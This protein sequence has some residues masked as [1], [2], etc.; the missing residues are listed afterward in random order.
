MATTK[1][2]TMPAPDSF[3]L[4]R[5]KL[6]AARQELTA[7]VTAEAAKTS[8]EVGFPRVG[9]PDAPDTYA[10]LRV[11]YRRSCSTGIALPVSNSNLNGSLYLHTQADLALRFWH[12]VSHVR[13][14]RSFSA[15]DELDLGLWHVAVAQTAGLSPLALAL[16]DADL[17][18]Q[19]L[20]YAATKGYA[21]NQMRFDVEAV[22]FGIADAIVL[23]KERQTLRAA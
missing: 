5:F 13:R 3:D 9:V 16:L 20:L 17:V 12:D 8:R 7:F 18:G 21:E 23:E 2:S 4:S 22:A 11:A 6:L 19:T 1:T 15:P 10:D 14:G